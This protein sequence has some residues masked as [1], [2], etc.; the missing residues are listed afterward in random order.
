MLYKKN[1]RH[2]YKNPRQIK[3]KEKPMKTTKEFTKILCYRPPRE[4]HPMKRERGKSRWT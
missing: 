4:S 3:K 2:N 1:I